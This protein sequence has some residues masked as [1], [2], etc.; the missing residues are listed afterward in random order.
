MRDFFIKII[1]LYINKIAKIYKNS[2][3]CYLLII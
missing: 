1:I 3:F 2:A